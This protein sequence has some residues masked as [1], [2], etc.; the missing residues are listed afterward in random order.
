M[1]AHRED[2]ERPTAEEMLARV[3]AEQPGT[4]GRLRVYL[5]MAP[6]VGKTYRMLEE[7]HR[8]RDRGT[9]VVVGFVETYGRR[10]TAALLDG[11]EAVPRARIEYRGVV[12]EEM[13]PQAV[14][15]RRSVRGTDRRAGA[16]E[17][18]RLA[19]REALAGCRVDPGRRDPC[20]QHVQCPARG[21]RCGGG[22]DHPGRSGPRAR[23]R[24]SRAGCGR[25]RAR[26]HEPARPPTA[27]A[28]RQRLSPGPRDDSPRA[29]LHGAEPGGAARSESAVR[30]RGGRRGARRT[31]IRTRAAGTAGC[32]R[33]GARRARR[34]PGVPARRAPRGGAGGGPARAADRGR[35][36]DAGGRR[37]RATGDRTCRRTSTTR[38]TSARRSCARRPPTSW[39][40]SSPSPAHDASPI[41]CWCMSRGRPSTASSGAR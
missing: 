41:S 15:E 28:P 14:M 36:G 38:S 33:A 39:P 20:H 9:D 34:P 2:A 23:A 6:G 18:A 35:R 32:Q 26:G 4:R 40:D 24:R 7:A 29:V 30:G 16:H 11:L 21:V 25:D 17:R 1:T 19:P 37:C 5:G 12:V 27:H 8:R 3:Q 31:R 22:G 10:H 13:D